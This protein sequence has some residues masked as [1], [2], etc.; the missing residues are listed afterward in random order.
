MPSFDSFNKFISEASLRGNIGIPGEEGSGRESWLDA[1]T[2]RGDAASREFASQNRQ[3]IANFG[4][5]VG[6][7]LQLQRGHEKELSKLTVDSFTELFGSL[8]EDTELDFKITTSDEIN[9]RVSKTPKEKETES[10]LPEFEELDPKLAG[11]VHKRKILRTVQQGKGLSS[12][13]I[14]NLSI[15]K[16][17]LVE[18]MGREAASE[19]LTL[20]NKISN[21]AQFFDWT[22]PEDQKKQ[23]WQMRPNFSG[24]S[25]IEIKKKGGEESETPEELAKKVIEEI[26][27]GKEVNDIPEADELM[28]D[29]ETKIIARGLEL[30][31]L[32]YESIKAVYKLIT[33]A[34]LESLYGGDAEKVLL[35]TDTLFD[36]LQEQ[37]FGTQ[38][39]AAF[40]KIVRES[41]PVRKRID[42]MIKDDESDV[43]IASFQ[44]RVDYLFFNELAQLGQEDP[45]EFLDLVNGILSESK[46]ADTECKPLIEKVLK[47]I[48][49]EAEYQSWK[50]GETEVKPEFPAPTEPTQR[51]SKDEIADA[52]I[53]AYQRGDEEEVARLRR[54]L[55]ESISFL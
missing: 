49:Q 30:S 10:D 21:V 48:D 54:L 41:E 28:K 55:K 5:L 29:F 15:F 3:D 47:S 51:M 35:N 14:L 4:Q 27:S 6:R 53:D 13:S 23:M 25:E 16:N 52:I 20:L 26:E 37:K 12:K 7:S 2:R 1:I 39:Q 44:E 42:Q 38:M 31:V 36:E 45:K 9:Q 40:F 19:Y 33:Q 32:I 17:G 34:S 22:V 46:E 18:I 43:T 50:R 11:H 24:V 8:L